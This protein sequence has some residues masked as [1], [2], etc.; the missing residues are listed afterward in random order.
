MT[1]A[2][3]NNATNLPDV[4]AMAKAICS[5][6]TDKMGN[7]PHPDHVVVHEHPRTGELVY[8]AVFTYDGCPKDA[9]RFMGDLVAPRISGLDKQSLANLMKICASGKQPREQSC[10]QLEEHDDF[11]K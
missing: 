3:F 6:Y 7:S 2:F 9:S 5:T 1:T 4:I 8:V 11:F 10:Y